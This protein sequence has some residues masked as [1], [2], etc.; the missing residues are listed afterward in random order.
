MEI[1]GDE[2]AR[3]VARA[4]DRGARLI[5]AAILSTNAGS[6]RRMQAMM[7]L[8]EQLLKKQEKTDAGETD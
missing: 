2:Q 1:T 7:V 3:I 6:T 4:I 5:A 8:V